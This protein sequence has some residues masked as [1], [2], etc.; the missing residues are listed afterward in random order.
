MKF[1]R[2]KPFTTRSGGVSKIRRDNY[3]KP[4]D[5]FSLVKDVHVRDRGVCQNRVNGALC[6]KK[7][8]HVHHIVPLSRGGVTRLSNLILFCEDCHKRRHSHM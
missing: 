1:T 6:G 7:G 5:W 4:S 8:N 2:S 3:G